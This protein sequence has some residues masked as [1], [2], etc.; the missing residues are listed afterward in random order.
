[1]SGIVDLLAS[2]VPRTKH[3]LHLV[4]CVCVCMYVH[5]VCVCV[6]AGKAI[7]FGGI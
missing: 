4:L 7:F 3:N 6:C 5:C 2:Q 1:M